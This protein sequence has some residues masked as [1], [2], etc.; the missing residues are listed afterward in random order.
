MQSILP[1]HFSAFSLVFSKCT[2][3]FIHLSNHT[4][5]YLNTS[6]FSIL[7]SLIFHS[8]PLPFPPTVIVSLFLLLNHASTSNHLEHSL[9][10][11]TLASSPSYNLLHTLTNSSWKPN[12]LISTILLTTQYYFPCLHPEM[13]KMSVSLLTIISHTQGPDQ[14]ILTLTL[15]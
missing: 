5:W 2:F 1:S 10:N 15:C 3:P 4:P 14:H 11:N 6:T 13:A 8:P 7:S 9:P 12:S